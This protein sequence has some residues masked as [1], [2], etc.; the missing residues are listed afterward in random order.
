[1]FVATTTLFIAISSSAFEGQFFWTGNNLISHLREFEKAE[2]S[3]PSVDYKRAYMF[4]GYVLAVYDSNS[5][6]LCPGELV[7]MRQICS[8]VAKYVNDHPAEWNKPAA[9]LVHSALQHAFP[10][11]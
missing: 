8:V 6:G 11:K 10:C 5:D 3:D 7:T 4:T 2:R 9:S 1:M